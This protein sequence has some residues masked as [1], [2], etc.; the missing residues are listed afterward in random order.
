MVLVVLPLILLFG[1]LGA[2][3]KRRRL[4]HAVRDRAFYL[5]RLAFGILIGFKFQLFLLVLRMLL[6][7]LIP[8]VSWSSGFL[9]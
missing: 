9:S 5:A 4:V 2:P 8:L 1:L 6:I 7:G 3:G